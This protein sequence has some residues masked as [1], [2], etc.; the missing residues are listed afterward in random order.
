[1]QHVAR[2][3]SLSVNA[4]ALVARMPINV[5]RRRQQE[6]L[7]HQIAWGQVASLSPYHS[8]CGRWTPAARRAGQEEQWTSVTKERET[9][10]LLLPCFRRSEAPLLSVRGSASGESRR[11]LLPLAT[12]CDCD[13]SL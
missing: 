4:S 1:M 9:R 11:L 13:C 8:V 7:A 10:Q 2:D 6:H 5:P 12:D 3:P